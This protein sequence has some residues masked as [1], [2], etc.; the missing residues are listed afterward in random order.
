MKTPLAQL[1]TV[2]IPAK[3][4]AQ[5]LP[6]LIRDLSRQAGSR[7]LEIIVAD[8]GS[9]DSTPQIA[10]RLSFIYDNLKIRI[11]PGG[12]V[13]QGRNAGLRQVNTPFVVFIDADAQLPHTHTLL[14]TVN[15]L[16]HYDLVGSHLR[17]NSWWSFSTVAYALFNLGNAL[18]SHWRPFAVGSYFATSTRAIRTAGGFRED[19]I[20]S[21]DWLVSAKYNPQRF[22][23]LPYR[24]A[25]RVDD[26]RFRRT[27]YL[28]MLRV[29]LCSLISGERYMKRDNGYWD[30]YK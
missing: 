18:L 7:G 16:Q 15:R 26:R 12:T 17:S 25:I 20:H 10:K 14:S 11:I 4:E 5:R 27:G 22:T 29:L 2:V 3:N 8:G 19:V 13:S 23:L 6:T 28:G 24:Y 30:Y 21:E 1:I 9:T